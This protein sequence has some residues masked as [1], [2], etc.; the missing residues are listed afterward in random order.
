MERF[1]GR[2]NLIKGK[3]EIFTTNQ[4]TICY[5]TTQAVDQISSEGISTKQL[6]AVNVPTGQKS[7]EFLVEKIALDL[8]VSRES[9]QTSLASFTL[10]DRRN[11]IIERQ[12]VTIIDNSYNISPMVA[13]AMLQEAVVTAKAAGK[14]LVVMTGGIG[15]QGKDE[16]AVNQSLAELLNA[17]T[18]RIIINPTIYAEH[19]TEM[20]TVPYMIVVLRT[21]VTDNPATYLDGE[22][23]ILLWL[24]G[25]GDLAYV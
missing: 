3:C 9:T 2:S 25:H 16:R 15:E 14:K 18:T 12:G 21:D 4:K 24:T 17:H 7:T 8:G 23:E 20:L 11:N 19:M 1:G 10:P 13:E 5:T 6:V 22:K